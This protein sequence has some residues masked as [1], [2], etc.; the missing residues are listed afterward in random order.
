MSTNDLIPSERDLQVQPVFSGRLFKR[1][2]SMVRGLRVRLGS[3]RFSRS[4][5]KEKLETE[6]A[7]T[8]SLF[9]DATSQM[10]VQQAASWQSAT[11][12]W[13]ELVHKQ[14]LTS[15]RETLLSINQE[16]QQTKKLKKDFIHNKA[17]Q[18]TAY[19]NASE[20]LKQKS[21]EASL[22]KKSARDSIKSKL[23][24]ERATLEQEMHECREW[25][26]IRTG[27]VALQELSASNTAD[28]LNDAQSITSLPHVAKRFEEIKKGLSVSIFRMQNHSVVKL[29]GSYWFLGMGVLLGAAT[30]GICWAM[31]IAPFL[32]GIVGVFSSVLFVAIIH[33]VT[34]PMVARAIRR[35]F[36]TIADQENSGYLVIVQGRRIADFNC[37]QEIDRIKRQYETSQQK[38]DEENRKK[39]TELLENFDATKTKLKESFGQKRKTLATVRKEKC[40]RFN[41]DRKPKI[42]SLE[43]QQAN[44]GTESERRYQER[45]ALLESNFQKSQE[46]TVRRWMDGCKYSSNFM[47][48]VSERSREDLPDWSSERYTNGDWPRLQNTLAWPLGDIE[49]L[50]QFQKEVQELALAEQTPQQPWNVFFDVIS[51][52]AL[53]IET[54]AECKDLASTIVRNTLLRAVTS[55]PAGNLNITIVDPEGL[56]KQFSWLMALAD[57]DPAMVNHR[58]WT[59]SLHIAEQL[60]LTARHVEDVIQQSLRNRYPSVLEYNQNAGPMSIPYRLIVW[61]NFP[62]GLDDSSWQSLCS[63]MSSGGRC[64]VGVIL[65][66]SDT[67]VWPSFA[68]RSKLNEF[69]LRLKLTPEPIESAKNG[70]PSITRTKVLIDQPELIHYPLRPELPPSDDRLQ[71]IM[72]QHLKAASEVGKCIVRY[73]SIALP[74]EEQ[75]TASSAEGLAIPLGISDAGRIQSMKLGAGT[76]QHVLIAG[77]TGSGKS[78][79]LHTM[80]T[81]AAMKYGPDQLR[82]V[83]LDF[84]KG[85]EFQVYS[86]VELSHADII[87]IESKR[88]FGVSTLEYLDRVLHARG[89]AFRQWGVQDIPS[90]SKKF[91]QHAMPRILVVIDEFQELFVE[92]DKLSQQAS[93][94]MDRIVRQGRSFGMH[95]VL[96]SQT[97]G[98]AYSLPRTTLSQMAVRIAL[99][100]DSSDA[101]LILS[102]DNTAAERLRHSGQAIYNELGGRIESNQSFQV[103]FVEKNDQISR[104]RKLKMVPVPHSPTTN[105]L[106]RR[107]VFEGHK[108]AVW[109]EKSVEFAI[110]QL[111][112]DE[113]AVPLILGDSVSID[114]P[115]TKILTRAAGRNLMVIGQDESSA[116]SLLAGSIAGFIYRPSVNPVDG[117]PS[118]VV[119]DGSRAED[120]SMRLLIS[121]LPNSKVPVRVGDV[122]TI[123]AT[124]EFLQNE[125]NFRSENSELTHPAMLIAV[126]N[127]SRFRELRRNEEYVF[128]EDAASVPKPDAVLANMLRDGPA[129]G[130]HVWLWADSVGTMTRWISRQSLRDLELR[131]LMQMSASDSNQLIDS[132]AAN[133]LDRYVVLIQDDIEG[134]PIKFRPFELQSVIKRLG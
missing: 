44:E 51:Q 75:Q 9:V 77:K 59:Q 5:D 3:L 37:Q 21:E 43:K 114:P 50:A 121:Q 88:E 56:G 70:T 45:L 36:P 42:E 107:I 11:T 47:R 106:G 86:E 90:L 15:E 60:A 104:L 33:F 69:G 16:Q 83:L 79:M 66:V 120:E 17:A 10:V 49:P 119:L 102:E 53:T 8:Q 54:H 73:E 109:D 18:K 80:I 117:K 89:E 39:R 74:I 87:G 6:R 97:L 129:L 67:Y 52:G 27:D 63:I 81:S 20:E 41:S 99:Q 24:R 130:M 2:V 30:A 71:E 92:D 29:L 122:R 91:P 40:D 96:A 95:L 14:F 131:I 25:V 94:L 76:A 124:I 105:A 132:N 38:L 133:R 1:Q 61:S 4:A 46:R 115:V 134:K 72:V 22:A 32:V 93:M 68:D 78:S 48:D 13:D 55:V 31:A 126:V 82:L 35:M 23:D 7:R 127:L 110:S 116:A 64:G 98:G 58:V 28:S 12:E 85:V 112:M 128:G 111:R 65:Q 118:I 123:D 101:M 108:P 19:E 26:G 34:A 57:V 125:L 100:C 103:A 113:G 62:F 84:K